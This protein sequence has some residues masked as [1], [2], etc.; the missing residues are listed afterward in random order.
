MSRRSLFILWAISFFIFFLFCS[1]LEGAERKKYLKIGADPLRF[2]R[3]LEQGEKFFSL[4][5]DTFVVSKGKKKISRGWVR[6]GEIVAAK[7]LDGRWKAVWIKRCGNEILNEIYLDVAPVAKPAQSEICDPCKDLLKITDIVIASDEQAQF[8]G[9][10]NSPSKKRIRVA[11][12][13]ATDADFKKVIRTNYLESSD[14]N[15]VL[16]NVWGNSFSLEKDSK[17]FVR[18]I[19]EINGMICVSKMVSFS[20]P[21]LME[22][23]EEEE[24][25][26]YYYTTSPGY[27]W[28]GETSYYRREY[29]PARSIPALRPP[30]LRPSPSPTQHPPPTPP[31]AHP[32]APPMS[33]PAHPAPPPMH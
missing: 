6:A 3:P 12:E 9:E 24:T 17:Y 28:Y 4:D 19:G 23:E 32:P 33:G 13:Y 11:F 14:L 26:P 18:M 25:M 7:N 16:G 22:Q 15:L 29:A 2:E 1:F 10:V 20:L 31:A 8:W 30:A 5:K 27:G 21:E